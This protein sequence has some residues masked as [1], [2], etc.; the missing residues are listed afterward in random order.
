MQFGKSLEMNFN[1][2]N[3]SNN[4]Y[5]LGELMDRGSV[6]FQ[7][8]LGCPG[9]AVSAYRV[10]GQCMLGCGTAIITLFQIMAA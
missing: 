5:E 2:L 6:Y 9:P 3:I 7:N 1:M 4:M 10:P 8:G